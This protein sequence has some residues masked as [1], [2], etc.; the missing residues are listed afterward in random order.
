M[1]N[2]NKRV[3]NNIYNFDN[4]TFFKTYKAVSVNLFLIVMATLFSI[5]FTQNEFCVLNPFNH[6]AHFA[7]RS[8]YMYLW[9]DDLDV[10]N[11]SPKLS[12]LSE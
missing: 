4:T 5:Y 2:N 11:L 12:R 1:Q 6:L 10:L 9:V 3:V 8:P 7:P